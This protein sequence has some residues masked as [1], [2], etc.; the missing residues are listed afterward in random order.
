[1]II[2]DRLIYASLLAAFFLLVSP[3]TAQREPDP[4]TGKIS[5]RRQ[6]IMDGNL[7]RTIFIN[8][9]EIAHWPDQPSG[10]WP[11]GSGHSYV[12][13]VALVVQART[14]DNDGK[15]IYPMET[16]YREFVDKGPND[17]LWGWG[18]LPG[19]FNELGDEPAMSDDPKTWPYRW[20][21]NPDWYDEK[22]GRAVW[23]GWRG[24]GIIQADLETYFVFDDDPDE[25]WNF[26]PDPGNPERRGLGLEVAARLFQWNNVL[27]ED[28]IFAIYFI[29][30]EGKTDYDSTY[31]TFYIDWGVGGTDDSSD[32]TGDYETVLDIAF[33]YDFNGLGTPGQ[34]GPVGVAGFAFLESPGKF[35]DGK[36]NDEDGVID[37]RRDSGPGVWLGSP[38][39]GVSN[40]NDFKRFYNRDPKP[41]WSGDEDQ[42]W[43]GYEDL[44]ENGKWDKGE[45][46]HDDVG[47][48]G[49]G[50]FSSGYPGPD[51]GEADG[52]PTAGEPNF[53]Y[54]DKDESDQ[55]GLT[56]FAIFPVHTYELHNE[57]QDWKVFS[58]ALPPREGLQVTANLG[59]F[60][61]SGPFS[62]KAGQTENYSMA[63]LFG[64]DMIDPDPAIGDHL[65]D[66]APTK[67]AVQS[68][69]NADYTFAVPPDKPTLTVIPGDGKVTLIWDSKSEDS[70]D[71]FLQEYDFEGYRI[72]RATEPELYETRLITDG[73][74]R[75]TYRKPIAQ[76]DLKDGIKGLHPIDVHGAHFDMGNDTG[77]RHMYVDK[78]VKNGQTY[79]YALVAYDRGYIDTTGV[80]S[81]VGI[82][83][84]ECGS[85]IKHDVSGNIEV[86]INTA[87]VTPNPRAIGYLAP[88][89]EN[90]LDHTGPATGSIDL[91][92]VYED[93]VLDGHSYSVIF[94]DSSQFHNSGTSYYEIYDVTGGDSVLLVEK[95]EFV[96]SAESPIIDGMVLTIDNDETVEVNSDLT[97][98][99][100]GDCNYR[101]T[102]DFD[103][104][105]TS[106]TNQVFNIN[107]PNPADYEIR[108][109]DTIVD[110]SNSGNL[111]YPEVPVYFSVYN[112]T[113]DK[114]AKFLF[115]DYVADGTL[116][117]DTT[118]SILIYEDNPNT[119]FKISTTWRISF[120][121][122]TLKPEIIE[123][124]PGDVF[125]ISTSKPFRTGD[126]IC[127]TVKGM[128]FDQQVAESEMDRISVVPN[129][130][131][132]AASWEPKSPYRFG[133]GER[134]IWF[135]HLPERCTIRIY[136]VRGYLVDTIEH[137]GA[138]GEG[139]ESWDLV[140][141]DGMDIAYGIYIFHVDAPG[142]GEKIGKFAVIK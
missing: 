74:G 100:K 18:P 93:S 2:K 132:A 46:L 56:G 127:F 61:S 103:P 82:A 137:Y 52:K 31:Y 1:M 36:D 140:S 29:T 123:P 21:D 116:T 19:Y 40:E 53:D 27:A 104:R 121:T 110:T 95:T 101:V 63:L 72:Y 108:F 68:I 24:K 75:L 130:Y 118:E 23:N 49:L 43:R 65:G 107:F 26:F 124:Q 48:D 39:Y 89:L 94:S 11:K 33:A 135:I 59:M 28:C 105:F 37:E 102:I 13:G 98:W 66:L 88:Q 4:N 25:E 3:V 44:N 10:E 120:M 47:A 115:R 60:F 91:Q 119:T 69:Y 6:G 87:V 142:I 64:D 20:P 97:G 57:N 54:L 62:V 45:P 106:E 70:Y 67:K 136:T 16:Q 90:G 22:T 35:T 141:K 9:G 139:A 96:E 111:G 83:P 78:D 117:P 125:K 41:H 50:P 14:V 30:N 126:V 32:D 80:G 71:P 112:V 114:P 85:V 134:R 138:G 8:W 84:S 81:K 109:S 58:S 42:D 15:V 79:Y 34:W 99:Q 51:E 129:P 55:I 17:E 92:F 5:Y 7:V 128:R 73:Y 12:D 122:D 77:L 86:D 76:F 113:D 38:P 131:V 133:R